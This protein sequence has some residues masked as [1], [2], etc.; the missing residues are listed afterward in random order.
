[1]TISH[2][3]SNAQADA[4]GTLTVWNGATTASVAATDVVRPSNW[5][6]AHNQ[7][8]TLSGNTNG[9]STASG[10]NVV[11][12]GMGNVTLVGSTGTIGISVAGGTA[13]MWQPFNEGVNVAG[14]R[15]QG[16]WALAPLPTP[17]TAAGGVVS[18]DRVCFPI[19]FSNSSNS[20]GT[21]SVTMSIGLYTKNA[22]SL[23]LAHSTTG[24]L[25]VTYSGTV[26][27]STYAGVRLMTVPWTTSFGDDRYYVAIA[28]S[29]ATGGNNCTV[30]QMLISQVNSNFS[31]LFGA[32]S[33]RSNQWPVGW[34]NYSAASGAFPNPIPI[35]HIDGTASLAAR[36]PSWF[37]INGTV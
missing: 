3:F 15:G 16:S 34:G 37:M 35:S 11:L 8:Y 24:T 22:S 4:T 26:N 12:Q 2:V 6:S 27:N 17:P 13:T 32:N 10:T 36:P 5:N 9:A 28:S 1:M 7:Y 31:G 33:N 19:V 29:T 23:S 18:I 25:A 20:T 14:Q 30:S 21:A